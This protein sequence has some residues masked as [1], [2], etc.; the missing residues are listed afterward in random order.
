MQKFFFLTLLGLFLCSYAEITP[1]RVG[2][3]SQYGKLL[4]GKN[5]SGKGQIYGSCDSIVTGKEVQVKGMSLFWSIGTEGYLF[6]NDAS[7]SKLVSDLKIQIIRAAMGTSDDWGDNEWNK[8]YTINSTYQKALI[9]AVVESAIK[10]DIYVI[11]DWHSH[12]AHEQTSSAKEFFSQMAQK[13][14]KYDHVIFEIYNEPTDLEWYSIKNYAEEVITEIRKY[15][16]NLVVVGTPSWDQK[17]NAAVGNTV[18]QENVAY[19]FHYYAGSHCFSGQ[20]SWGSN[21]EGE[22]AVNAMNA[23]L[24]VF[25]TEWGTVNANGNGSVASTN[26]GW[27]NWMNEHKLSWAN[28]SVSNKAEGASIFSTSATATDNWSYTSSGEYIKTKLS[29]NPDSYTSC[30]VIDPILD[31]KQASSGF[32]LSALSQGIRLSTNQNASIEIEVFDLL[33]QK[34]FAQQDLFNQGTYIFPLDKIKAG[35]YIVRAKMGN[36]IQTLSI[37]IQ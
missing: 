13:Y 36:Q 2:P 29:S 33:G 25:V 3:V 19:T 10:N 14:G 21:C 31:V 15:S 34:V 16:D 12:S 37:K 17:T 30:K 4:A 7:V 23:G 1:T 28:W 8:G 6:Y 35:N 22:N 24:S 32:K 26:D 20:T 5:S 27:Q 9:E 11:I 18:N